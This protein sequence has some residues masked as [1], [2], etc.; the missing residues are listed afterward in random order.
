MFRFHL[1]GTPPQSYREAFQTKKEIELINSLLDRLFLEEKMLLV[2]TGSCM[3]STALTIREVD[4]L[5]E[6]VLKGL[7]ILKPEL[8]NYNKTQP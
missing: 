7:K 1:R 4:R 8:E 3:F 6:A 2:N 5:S